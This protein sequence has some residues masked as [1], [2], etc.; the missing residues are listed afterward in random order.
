MLRYYIIF[1]GIRPSNQLSTFASQHIPG[2]TLTTCTY[3]ASY[4]NSIWPDTRK[5]GSTRCWPQD[6]H[7]SDHSD[8]SGTTS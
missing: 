2:V 6:S 7:S 5:I 8:L 1:S 4:E 3:E